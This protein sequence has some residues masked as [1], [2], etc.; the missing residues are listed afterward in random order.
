MNMHRLDPAELHSSAL[1]EG[2]PHVA[3]GTSNST[4]GQLPR[5]RTKHV[6]P[7]GALEAD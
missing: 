5:L 6:F 4:P 1:P 2:T 7:V 3:A